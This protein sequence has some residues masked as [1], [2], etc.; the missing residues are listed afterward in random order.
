MAHI[1]RKKDVGVIVHKHGVGFRVWAP[2]ANTIA[3]TGSFNDWSRTPLESEGDGYWYV[4]IQNAEVGQEYKYIINS[5]KDDLYHNDPRALQLTTTAGNSVIA[6]PNFDWDDQAEFIKV[7]LNHQ[8]IY[9]LHVG[10]FARIDASTPGTFKEVST[11][12]DYLSEL[13][14]TTIELM[15]ICSMSM[16]RGW[17]YAPDYMY[18]VE[19]LYGGRAEFLEFVKA[20][21]ARGIAV[22]LDVVYNHLGPDEHLDLW[23]FDGWNLSGKGG[24][25]F[26]ND[27]RSKTPWGETRPDYGRPEVR[28]YIT[29]N[30]LMW[31]KDCHLDGLRLDSTIYM[32]NVDGKNDDQP[33]DLADG[34]GILQE[35]TELAFKISPETLIIAEDVGGN[36]FITKK[37]EDGGAG[38]SSQWNVQF[39][40]VV[41]SVLESPKDEE[42]DLTALC[43]ALKDKHNSDVFERIIYS[44]SHDS[45]ANGGA[46]LTEE[47]APGDADNVYARRRSLLAAAIV[48]TAPGIPMLFQGQEFLEDGSFNDWQVLDWDKADRFSGMVLAYKHLIALRKNIYDN[49]NGLTG[50][51]FSVVHLNEESKVLAY[52]RWEEGGVGDDVV[53]VYNFTN[54]MLKN[55]SINFPAAGTWHIRFNSDWQG[56]SQD[57]KSSESIPIT[58]ENSVANLTLPPYTV[59]ILSQDKDA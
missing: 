37:V 46:R 9:E 35:V 45:A 13:G 29:D 12:L 55:Y 24:I 26:Y 15:P 7:P 32:R 34:W 14:I 16:D 47:I 22:I 11:K 44:D 2:F 30:V 6:D 39:P 31:L 23:Q 5:G 4:Q 43:E 28:Q 50:Q 33:N 25:Y 58:V 48:L 3:L 1:S 42:R 49:V 36:D 52:H 10:T 51:N 8:V 41:R 57:F 27:W 53:V 17:G 21:H 40:S 38:F 19:S 18:A 20:A 56:Y 54:H 59:L